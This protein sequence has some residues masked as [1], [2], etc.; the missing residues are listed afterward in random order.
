VSGQRHAPA[1]LYPRG[2]D[3]RYPLYRRLGG[4]QSRF[5]HRGYRKNP[6]P[7]PGIEPRSPG[8]PARSQTL[9]CLS[10]PAPLIV[11]VAQGNSS[12]KQ[13]N[14]T[15][16]QIKSRFRECKLP[17]S[18]FRIFHSTGRSG[19]DPRQGKR[20]FPLASVSRPTLWPTQPPVQCVPGVLSPGLMDDL[21]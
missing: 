13:T 21:A 4:P 11:Y 7:L 16:Q 1:A 20:I 3:P 12:N 5:E 2:K 10:Y 6:L 18:S 8:R 14:T 15:F 9:Y 17:F 19:F